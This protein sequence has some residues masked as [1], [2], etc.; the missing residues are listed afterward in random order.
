MVYTTFSP[1]WFFG[2]DI[3][4]EFAFAVISLIVAI[5]AYKI[6][7]KTSQKTVMLFGTSFLLISISYFIQSLLNFL[8][9]SKANEQVC[10]II[11]VQSISLFNQCGMFIHIFFMTIGLAI[12]VYITFKTENS[13]PLFLLVLISLLWIFLGQNTIFKFYLLTTVYLIFIGGHYISN[14]FKNKQTKT[15]LVAIAFLFLLF[16]KIHFLIS[17]NH[18]LLY[19]IG[20][21]LELFAYLL[22]LTNL[23]LVFK[24]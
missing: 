15:L 17:V 12:F 24:K 6:Y 16:G 1:I 2:Y 7:K 20:H 18:Q 11:K 13:K 22:I 8:I 19:A 21:I 14:Y 10:R 3:A 9:I 5:L 4:L 23:Y